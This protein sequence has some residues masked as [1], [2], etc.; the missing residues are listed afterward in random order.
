M[1]PQPVMVVNGQMCLIF[2]L[3]L[4]VIGTL[5]IP[6]VFSKRHLSKVPLWGAELGAKSRRDAL[7][8]NSKSIYIE[9]YQKV[10][11]LISIIPEFI[12]N[13]RS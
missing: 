7:L 4:L 6:R 11:N 2:T 9:S 8:K 12:L 5:I 10:I 3:A 1:E 13:P